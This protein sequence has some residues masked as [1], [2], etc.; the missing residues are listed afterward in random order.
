METESMQCIVTEQP[1]TEII[2]EPEIQNQ[3]A[4]IT[5][6]PTSL[7]EIPQHNSCCCYY[8]STM[9]DCINSV[10]D[11]FSIYQILGCLTNCCACNGDYVCNGD[12]DCDCDC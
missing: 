4:V 6:P 8:C 11:F 1:F 2:I 7:S 5:S 12:C 10:L 3:T 9:V